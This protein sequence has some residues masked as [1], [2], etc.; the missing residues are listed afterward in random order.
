MSEQ[1]P[2]LR[3]VEHLSELRR[4]IIWVLAVFVAALVAGFIVAGPVIQY[5]KRAPIAA[6]FT[7][8]VF[9]L[10]DGLRV[11]MQFAF[12]IAIVIT[13]PFMMYHIWRFV[14]P[15]LRPEERKAAGAFII[16]AFLLFI[17]GLLMGYYVLF[18]MI[19]GFMK[20]FAVDLGANTTYG[21]AQYFS[22]MF[23]IILPF[24]LLFELPIV[25][26]FLTRLRILNPIRLRKVRGY[27]YIVL[28]IVASM[29]SPPDLISHLSVFIP[30][31]ILYEL[32]VM[33]S[34]VVYDKQLK[35]D[36]ELDKELDAVDDGR[37]MPGSSNEE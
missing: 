24:A 30:L 20:K 7:W 4:R 27:A 32:S 35:E 22:F 13:S 5:F 15:G 21:I 18:P 1:G 14:S 33:L 12:V 28:I 26:M 9:G 29:I 10:G 17:A 8:N 6:G 19:V 36:L 37:K 34:R 3:V 31:I 2:E 16:P 11:Y 23:N 25:V